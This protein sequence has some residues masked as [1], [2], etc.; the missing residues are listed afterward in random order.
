MPISLPPHALSLSH[1]LALVVPDILKSPEKIA[2]SAAQVRECSKRYAI[3]VDD[4]GV[5][6]DKSGKSLKGI[7]NSLSLDSTRNVVWNE[8]VDLS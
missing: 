5:L 4:L 6:P 8:G 3:F 7:P 2:L 1:A